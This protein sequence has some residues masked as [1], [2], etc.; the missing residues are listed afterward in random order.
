[1]RCSKNNFKK[2]G[3]NDASL[4]QETR[5]ISN[6][7]YLTK[8]L[9]K[10]KKKNKERP[11]LA[12]KKK[13]QGVNIPNIQ[14][15]H[16]TQYQK[17]KNLIKKWAEHPKKRSSF[18]KR[19]YRCL[20]NTWQDVQHWIIREMEIKTTMRCHYTL[21]RMTNIKKSINNKCWRRCGERELSYTIA[22]NINWS[23]HYGKQ[24]RGSLK[25][26]NRITTISRNSMPRYISKKIE[27]C[28]SKW[29]IHPD[30]HSSTIA[31]T[32]KSLKCPA[33]DDCLRKMWDMCTVKY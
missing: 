14:T 9:E 27:N 19:T 17:A 28:N 11:N 1:M 32:Q 5:K 30:I 10:R 26:N 12:E 29:Y 2:E 25:S 3:H 22:G 31:K 24:Y 21:L 4:P 18:P 13:I 16:T 6:V 20:T 33:T 15:A 8:Q 23:N 7:T